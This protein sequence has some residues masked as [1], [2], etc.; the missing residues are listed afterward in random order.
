MP[1]NEI[2]LLNKQVLKRR[3][4]AFRK[5]FLTDGKMS[6]NQRIV[7][8]TL[9]IHAKTRDRTQGDTELKILLTSGRQELLSWIH[10]YLDADKEE[11]RDLDRSIEKHED[12][13]REQ[14][15]I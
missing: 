11:R 5:V 8:E 12:A 6:D 10:F 7:M 15:E 9:E 1:D 4:Q 14:E 3:I 2:T 13:L